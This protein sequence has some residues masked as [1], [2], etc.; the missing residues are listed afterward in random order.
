MLLNIQNPLLLRKIVIAA[1]IAIFLYLVIIFSYQYR[2]YSVIKE[3]VNKTHTALKIDINPLDSLSS[4]YREADFLYRSYGIDHDAQTRQEY[5]R[6]ITLLGTSIGSFS[7]EKMLNYALLQGRSSKDEKE[8]L[9]T[10]IATLKQL[11]KELHALKHKPSDSDDAVT[12]IKQNNAL[13]QALGTKIE[14]IRERELRHIRK[15]E[16]RAFAAHQQ[17]VEKFESQL[18]VALLIILTMILLILV[19]HDRITKYETEL[20]NEK[21]YAAQVAEEKTSLLANISHEVRTPISSLLS[22]IDFLKKHAGNQQETSADYLD[23]ATHEIAMINSSI[24]DILTLSKLEVGHLEVKNEYLSPSTLLSAALAL[25][26]YSARQKGLAL[27][28]EIDLDDGLEIYSSMFRL[29]QIISNLL[30]NAIKY[31]ESGEIVL[32]AKLDEN[33]KTLVISVKDT[34]VGIAAQDQAHIFQQYI[35]IGSEPRFG[36]FGLGLYTSNLL[37]KQLGGHI[38]L[39][40]EPGRGSTFWLSIPVRDARFATAQTDQYSLKSV[41]RNLKIVCIDD[42]LVNAF[43]LKHYFID[44]Q[45]SAVFHKAAEALAYI[46]KNKVDIVI[47]DLHMPDIDGWTVLERVKSYNKDIRVF[48]F[49]SDYMYFNTEQQAVP[50]TFDGVLNK[51]LEDQQLVSVIRESYATPS[52]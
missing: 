38:S 52:P 47:T 35:T 6:K 50:Y 49:T 14:N 46:Y 2:R 37:A 18:I 5:S 27:S 16:I 26:S 24:N 51:P 12:Q 8:I 21:E 25:H 10:E 31:T 9:Q 17:N 29:K 34:G 42:N 48:L 43:Y 20:N 23:S 28:S 39:T 19:Y 4:I 13:L 1:L 22:I 15:A 30:S 44:F 41:S 32:A 45:H 7:I 33:R 40:S 3:R 36:S 11:V